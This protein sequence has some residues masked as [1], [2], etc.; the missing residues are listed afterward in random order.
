MSVLTITSNVVYGKKTGSTPDGRKSGEE[1]DWVDK[2]EVLPYHR[3][4]VYKWRQLGIPYTLEDIADPEPEDVHRAYRLIREGRS[5][6]N[7]V[8]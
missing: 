1:L 6:P 3:M 5:I 7:A 8:R 4:G 2:I